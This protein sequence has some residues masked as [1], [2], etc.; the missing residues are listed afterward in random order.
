MTLALRLM[1]L[2]LLVP[3]ARAASADGAS[4]HLFV[5]DAAALARAKA[6]VGGD[7]KPALDKLVAEAD[8]AIKAT[9]VSVMD[10]RLTPASGDRHDYMSVAPYF[11]PDP[12]KSDGLP[13]IRKDGQ[14]NPERGNKDTDA[15]GLGATVGGVQTLALAYYFTGNDAY[16]EHAAKNLRVWFLDP[17]T[18]MNPNL[19]FAQAIPGRVDG[20]GIGIID[21]TGMIGLVDAIGLLEGSKAWTAEDQRGMVAWFT[22][23][24]EWMQTSRNGNEEAA[25]KNNHGTWYDAQ[26]AAYALFIGKDDLARRTVEE[27]K[28]KR[29]DSQIKAD[30]S[31]PLELARTNSLSYSLYDLTAFFNLA[32]VG[33][34]VGVDLWNHRPAAGGGIRAALEFV[35]PYMDPGKAWPHEQINREKRMTNEL[36]TLLRRAAIAYH[37]PRYEE[38]L[39]AHAPPGLGANRMQLLYAR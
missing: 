30:G 21:A 23:F 25:A 13:Y 8:K 29:V 12:T 22:A 28:A 6:R 32:R 33:E 9:P 34:R 31:L 19:N 11:W 15:R 17:A 1:V 5:W 38:M 4:P 16:A 27:A 14:V 24:V 10:K 20:R 18:R 35:A 3:L 26:L 36:P 37:D 2:L 39:Q 7:L